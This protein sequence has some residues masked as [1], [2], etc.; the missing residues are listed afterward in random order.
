MVTTLK[1][2]AMNPS[3]AGR[4]KADGFTLIELLV[5]IAIIAILA[6]MLLP[7]LA[8]AKEKA[9]RTTCLNNEKQLY[10]SLHMY[11]DDNNDSQPLLT[12][13]MVG[14]WC[15]DT[16]KTATTAMLN[17]GCVKKTFYCPSTAPRFTDDEN[18]A[19]INHSD[20]WD[21]GG[22]FNITGYTWT[23]GGTASRI[24]PLYQNL[25]DISERH[26]DTT[27]PGSPTFTDDPSTREFITDVMLS[28]GTGATKGNELPA[29]GANN[30]DNVVGGFRIHHLSAHM[31]GQIPGG[32]NIAF[33]DG[34]VEWRKFDAS[35][36]SASGNI[37]KIRGGGPG[38]GPNTDP[39]FWF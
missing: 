26:I 4:R 11:C 17:S 30:F 34:H 23:F 5:V 38:G 36:S 13:N 18:Y 27:A 22:N 1:E 2:K 31:K 21:Y 25:K 37:T 28:Q 6:A 7:A 12:G 20:L 29:S 15:W 33:K 24:F 35:S 3:V 10:L 19:N 14:A 32:E 39:F 9:I 16:P 8:K